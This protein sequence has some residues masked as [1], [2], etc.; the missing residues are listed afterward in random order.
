M[1]A[2]QNNQ[3]IRRIDLC[4]GLVSTY[5]GSGPGDFKNGARL[6]ASLFAPLSVCADPFKSN[7]YFIGDIG[8]IR[9]CDGETVSLIAGGNLPGY[10]D[11]V[12]GAAIM[13]R[14]YGLI[15]TSD[16]Q[17][18]YFSDGSNKRLRCVELKT[19]AVKTVCGDGSHS[20]RDGVG[21]NASFGETHQIC[22]NRSPTTKPDSVIF[23]ASH[24]G[25][26]RFDIATGMCMC[27]RAIQFRNFSDVH[28]SCH[29]MSC[30]WIKHTR[31]DGDFWSGV[32]KRWISDC[33]S[34]SQQLTICDSYRDRCGGANRFRFSG[35]TQVA[36]RSGIE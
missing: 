15:C 3:K 1:C 30:R 21:T 27:M 11:G 8:S 25:V 6:E 35:Q 26:R 17:T 16:A 2:D 28:M 13:Y 20:R 19:R 31:T 36:T 10:N 18:L 12:G 5:I 9:Y 32:Y 29:V 14:V 23:I 22:F 34:L 33:L 7:C 24:P 4:H